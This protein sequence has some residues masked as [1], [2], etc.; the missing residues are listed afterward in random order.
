MRLYESDSLKPLE[1]TPFR[2]QFI[3]IYLIMSP[4]PHQCFIKKI[5]TQLFFPPF[6]LT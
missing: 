1:P 4:F 3:P 2:R 5:Y 6:L